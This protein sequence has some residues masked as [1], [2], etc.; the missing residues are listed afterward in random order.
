MNMNRDIPVQKGKTYQIDIKGLG[1]SGEGVGKYENFTVF[2]PFALPGET[3][4]ARID[5]VKKQYATAT[6]EE[7]LKPSPDRIKPL[8]PVYDRCGG[9]QL[10]H[11]SYEAELRE[12]QQQVKDAMTRIGH[13]PDLPVLPTLGAATPWSYRNKMQFPVSNGS[14]GQIRIGCFA[15]ATHHV[16]NVGECAIQKDENNEIMTVVRQWMKQYKIPAYNEDKRTGIVRH[17]MGRVGVHTGEIMV[18]L[19][20]AGDMVPHI[21]NLAHMLKAALPGLKSLVQNVNTRHTNVILGNKTKLI[22]GKQTIHDTIGTLTFNISAQSFF[23]V[24]SEQA[25]RLYETAMEF[26]DLTGN[27]IVADVYCGTGTITLFLAQQAKQVFGIEIVAPAIRDAVQNAKDNH[28][29]NAAF[30]LGDAAYKL[31]ELIRDGIHPDI[32]VLDPPRAGCEEK[33]LEAIAR[34]KPKKVVYISCNP[35][36]LARDLAYLTQHGFQ[37]IKAQPVDMFS[38]THHVETVA[39]LVRK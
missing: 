29:K 31:P 17:V 8:C 12:K 34:T 22:Y 1:S 21:K 9:C 39:L 5:F 38:R 20:T 25:Q 6:L 16:I 30:V 13:L 26:A 4:Q 28:I 11:L 23:Q 2:V 24:N 10:Q 18:C 15:A 32:I 27:E 14:K 7:V 36:T 37:A 3:V 35:A 19:V 33:V